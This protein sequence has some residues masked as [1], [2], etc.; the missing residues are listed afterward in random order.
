MV[1]DVKDLIYYAS[2]SHI[3]L[4]S[5]YESIK[6]C[7][8]IEVILEEINRDQFS[9][10]VD[11]LIKDNKSL[12][13]KIMGKNPRPLEK[14]DIIDDWESRGQPTSNKE[15]TSIL[16]SRGADPSA[17]KRTIK[18]Y[19]KDDLDS[20]LLKL[21][22]DI[23]NVGIEEPIIKYLKYKLKIKESLEEA[24]LSP[25]DIKRVISQISSAMKSSSSNRGDNTYLKDW[26][27]NFNSS[28]KAEKLRLSK[29]FINYVSDRKEDTRF[30]AYV[31]YGVSSIKS[32]DLPD[33]VKP[34]LI[35]ML[36]NGDPFTKIKA[37]KKDFIETPKNKQ[38]YNADRLR[39][40]KDTVSS[41]DIQ[42]FKSYISSWTSSFNDTNLT[43]K[44][45]LGKEAIN[46]ASDRRGDKGHEFLVS[47]FSKIIRDSYLPNNIKR[48][49]LNALR[50]GKYYNI[51]VESSTID[52]FINMISE[53]TSID[54]YGRIKRGNNV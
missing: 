19:N 48:S 45:K 26:K 39:D 3:E 5:L 1:N 51:K 38:T 50:D 41:S 32:S 13:A 25:D 24:V 49:Y 6:E 54:R 46:Y 8:D 23:K 33:S 29:E 43:G 44:V 27:E 2:L 22:K 31:S 16:K 47:T 30:E 15:I 35:K 12:F 9:D 40:K 7:D 53:C 34:Q 17:I 18:K 4:K 42:K 28:N 20:N 14:S 52:N 10:F 37:S 11:D 36:R 21:T